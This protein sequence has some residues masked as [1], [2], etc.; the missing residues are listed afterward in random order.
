MTT[1]TNADL[2]VDARADEATRRNTRVGLFALVLMPLTI[3]TMVALMVWLTA[4][5]R[6]T[7]SEPVPPPLPEQ[8][9][10]A[11]RAGEAPIQRIPR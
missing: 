4:S 8:G 6:P 2:P 10:I 5:L 9:A 3:A 1:A 11:E 7:R